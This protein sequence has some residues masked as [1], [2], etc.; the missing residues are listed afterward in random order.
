MGILA[1]HHRKV[2]VRGSGLACAPSF[3]RASR[4]FLRRRPILSRHRAQEVV[5][6]PLN[7][8]S[9]H[10]VAL[11]DPA[12]ELILLARD[13]VPIVLGQLA[14]LLSEAAAILFPLAFDLIPIHDL[15][16]PLKVWSRSNHAIFRNYC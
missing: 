11:L 10:A 5:Y 12:D 14:P 16:L 13:H 4:S 3:A 9:C 1:M 2:N 15:I 8:F 6:F 7:L